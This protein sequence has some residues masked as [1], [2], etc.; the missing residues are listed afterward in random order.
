MPEYDVYRTVHR[1]YTVQADTKKE[2]QLY[3][4][5]THHKDRDV[6]HNGGELVKVVLFAVPSEMEGFE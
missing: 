1:K 3:V 4:N 5:K 2:A 6:Q